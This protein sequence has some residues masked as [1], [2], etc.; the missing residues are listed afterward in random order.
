LQENSKRWVKLASFS[1][2]ECGSFADLVKAQHIVALK[3]DLNPE[4]FPELA[5]LKLVM[6]NF[7]ALKN[8]H[9]YI[10]NE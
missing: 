5:I 2:G 9:P 6:I 7:H 4:G 10:F 8:P 3:I 1:N